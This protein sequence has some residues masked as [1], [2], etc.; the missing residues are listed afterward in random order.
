MPRVRWLAVT[1]VAA[2]V[3]SACGG[4]DDSDSEAQPDESATSASAPAS[5]AED[6]FCQEAEDIVGTGKAPDQ[7]TIQEL[8]DAAPDEIADDFQVLADA[9]GDPKSADQDAVQE[10]QVNIQSWGEDNCK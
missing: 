1:M 10:A 2:S 4:S 7:A 9:M 5:G 3:L 6:P 8:A